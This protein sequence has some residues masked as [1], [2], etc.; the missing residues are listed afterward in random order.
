MPI[1]LKK[2]QKSSKLIN[3]VIVTIVLILLLFILFSNSQIG[4]TPSA[5]TSCFPSNSFSCYN[6]T[7][8]STTQ[9]ATFTLS[10][11]TGN[12]WSNAKIVFVP[13]GTQILNGTPDLNWNST[14]VSIG[15][16]P[17]G[18]NIDVM[19]PINENI[20][21]G[22]SSLGEVWASYEINNNSQIHYSQIALIT[23][24]AS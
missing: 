15:A 9:K 2:H 23:I 18:S 10:Q 14:S 16:L 6:I 11:N 12:D 8:S 5:P 4:S 20:S 17:N 19:V 1:S 3:A 24:H 21:S 13:S 7:Y 22:R